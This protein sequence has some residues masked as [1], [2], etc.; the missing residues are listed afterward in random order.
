MTSCCGPVLGRNVLELRGP[1]WGHFRGGGQSGRQ[2]EPI[3]SYGLVSDRP[4]STLQRE[5]QTRASSEPR[6]TNPSTR[7]QATA[8]PLDVSWRKLRAA[9]IPSTTP[10]DGRSRARNTGASQAPQ[11]SPPPC[12]TATGP[13]SACKGSPTHTAA[14]GMPSEPPGADPHAGWC[15]GRRGEL[16]AYPIHPADAGAA[17][18]EMGPAGP[19]AKRLTASRHPLPRSGVDTARLLWAAGQL[20]S[21]IGV[22]AG[23]ATN[24]QSRPRLGAIPFS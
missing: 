10:A 20:N 17:V 2:G 12:P 24:Q 4:H 6:A 15:G 19:S 18:T 14:S 8:R 1:V 9:D 7:S 16:G 13:S 3:S 23:A 5:T 11:S 22:A 21:S